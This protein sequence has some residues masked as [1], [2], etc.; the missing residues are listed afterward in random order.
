MIDTW[1]TTGEAA[2]E[3]VAV[4]EALALLDQVT[5]P[6]PPRAPLPAGHT[7]PTAA[8]A[9]QALAAAATTVADPGEAAQ[10]AEAGAALASPVAW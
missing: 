2:L 5:T 4:I 9:M 6:L 1:P 3:V 10:I 8:E 7:P